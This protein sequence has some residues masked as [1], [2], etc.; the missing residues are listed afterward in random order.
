MGMWLDFAQ[1][2]NPTL[3]VV[4]TLDAM[5]IHEVETMQEIFWQERKLNYMCLQ[6]FPIPLHELH[7]LKN[8]YYV[9]DI[10]N[11]SLFS[12]DF[13]RTLGT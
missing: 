7:V 3:E 12:N 1:Q 4:E 13:Y 6:K 10:F 8:A 5:E 11:I 2:Y 9:V